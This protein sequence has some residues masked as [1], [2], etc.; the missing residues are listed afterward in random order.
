M[1]RKNRNPWPVI[2]ILYL[3]VWPGGKT[4]RISGNNGE[5]EKVQQALEKLFSFNAKAN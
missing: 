3:R 5:R 1:A 2:G 4:G